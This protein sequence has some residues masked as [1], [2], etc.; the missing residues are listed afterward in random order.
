MRPPDPELELSHTLSFLNQTFTFLSSGGLQEIFSRKLGSCTY[1]DFGSGMPKRSR[2]TIYNSFT[3][4]L[5]LANYVLGHHL[6]EGWVIRAEGAGRRSFDIP[7]TTIGASKLGP[8][9]QGEIGAAA[10][11]AGISGGVDMY[12][13]L[14]LDLSIICIRYSI[15]IANYFAAFPQFP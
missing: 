9:H 12:V 13:T 8:D 1:F 10:A 15:R 11:I 5:T 2:T 14:H 4:V 6:S 3:F 7:I